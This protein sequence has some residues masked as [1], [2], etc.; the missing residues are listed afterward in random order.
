MKHVLYVEDN[1]ADAEL[2]DLAL[3]EV[4]AEVELHVVG[5]G[6]QAFEFLARRGGKAGVPPPPPDL[7][8]LDLNLPVFTGAMVLAELRRH[9]TWS[10]IPV[11]MYT[12]SNLDR[13]RALAT[14]LGARFENKPSNWDEALALAGRL[15]ACV[16][17][18]P[19]PDRRRPELV[20]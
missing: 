3:R 18:R 13:D 9:P 6:P 12:S 4:G 19:C 10:S 7:I 8:L 11:V 16:E 15:I 1:P 20:S 2:A 14:R 5:T 17:S